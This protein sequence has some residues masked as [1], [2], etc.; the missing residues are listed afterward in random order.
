[1]TEN[2]IPENNQKD[3]WWQPGLILFIKLSSWIGIPI[4]IA[5]FVGKFLDKKFKTEPWLFLLCVGI[6]FVFSMFALVV[7]G[8]NEMNR[9]EKE[10]KE[11]NKKFKK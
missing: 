9:I 10:A 11:N 8:K 3:S 5:V 1:M 7:Q 2:K 4:I 6:S